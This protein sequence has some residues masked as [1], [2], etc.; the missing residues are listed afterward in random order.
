MDGYAA[1]ARNGPRAALV[2]AVDQV[3]HDWEHRIASRAVEARAELVATCRRAVD[4][5]DELVG[6]QASARWL[7]TFP[8][9]RSSWDPE[10]Y[11]VHVSGDQ[12]LVVE[13]LGAIE[14]S[15]DVDERLIRIAS[16]S[17]PPDLSYVPPAPGQRRG[18]PGSPALKALA[19]AGPTLKDVAESM[20]RGGHVSD[21]SK[22]L[23]GKRPYP[24]ALVEVLEQLVDAET[25]ARILSLIPA[26]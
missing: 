24:E 21:V 25:A 6:L 3:G 9:W 16:R 8:T 2:T 26:T 18:R 23:A 17:A 4:L 20:P 10:P 11:T 12:V 22:W 13:L 1:D 14:D 15:C 7:R 5:H 19:E